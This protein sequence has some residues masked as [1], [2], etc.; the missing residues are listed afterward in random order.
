MTFLGHPARSVPRIEHRS[1]IVALLHGKG[2]R[3]QKER[4]SSGLEGW[5]SNEEAAAEH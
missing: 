2:T 1:S 3:T 4:S 5:G